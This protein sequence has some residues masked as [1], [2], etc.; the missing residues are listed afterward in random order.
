[1]PMDLLYA[2]EHLSCPNYR[3]EE[4]R[5]FYYHETARSESFTIDNNN[6]DCGLFLIEGELIL[7]LAEYDGLKIGRRQM[8]YIPQNG[9]G[10]VEAVSDAKWLL[11]YWDTVVNP[12]DKLF[13]SLLSV[14]KEEID[15]K[16]RILPVNEPVMNLLDTV[17]LYVQSGLLC[18]HMHLLKQQE[19]FI[20]MR[21]FYTKKQLAAFFCHSP[22]VAEPFERI[23][24]N[25]YREAGTVSELADLCNMS[26]RAF[27]RK[28]NEHFG[29]TP[30]QWLQK[31]RAEYIRDMINNPEISF[32]EI[33]FKLGFK[34]SSHFS[35]Y[36]RRCFGMSPSQ[37]RKQASAT[38]SDK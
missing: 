4:Q 25:K 6:S 27:S 22:L 2:E 19:L 18:K 21:G 12:C 32:K 34:T 35:S 17:P 13:L 29:E 36:C 24:L 5:G 28:F 9:G 3:K 37:M 15:E 16:D 33:G 7:N 23:V 20:V 8:L 10:T 31:K 14:R 38:W 30:Y 1:M 26:Q 11:L